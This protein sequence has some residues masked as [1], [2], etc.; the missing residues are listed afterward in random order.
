MEISGL[1][2]VMTVDAH[3]VTLHFRGLSAHADKKRASP[4]HIP[5]PAVAAV[6]FSPPSGLRSGHVRIAVVGE[7]AAVPK[8][9]RDV[10]ALLI[11]IGAQATAARLFTDEVAARLA[12]RTGA[13]GAAPYS[14]GA[15][16]S[17]VRDATG[18]MGVKVGARRELRK[19][20][21]HLLPGESVRYLASGT[22]ERRQ[23]LIALTD[24]RLLILFHG[25][26]RQ[27]VQD[28]PLD[29]ITS[30]REKAGMLLGTLTVLAS[31]TTL[32]ITNVSKTDMKALSNALRTR[33]STGSLPTLP[34]LE[35]PSSVA[36][37]N[38][39][40]GAGPAADALEQLARLGDLRNSGVLS[41][42][43]FAEAKA[44]LLGRL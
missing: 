3:G 11:N 9:N 5:W 30:I 16:A 41:E 43:E 21:G 22:V 29:R 7:T 4:R 42:V 8:P 35:V 27:D 28:L 18:R 20:S 17:T 10:N 6:Q 37:E 33:I 15:Q 2:G 36:D 19:L 1:D 24:R 39:A 13:S 12:A 23:G 34:P 40:H 14:P 31:N 25:V 26:V 32:V 38:D 44:Q